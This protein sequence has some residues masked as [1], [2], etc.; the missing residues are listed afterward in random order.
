MHIKT[1]PIERHT[2][3]VTVDNE[4]GVL[5]RIAGM[6]SARGYNIESL[7]VADISADDA[8]SRITIVTNG[9][10]AVIEQVEIAAKYSG[11][12]D[13]QK[14][15]VDRAAHFESLRLPASLDYL[16]VAAL[17]Y[18]VRQKLARHR[19]ETLGQASRMSGI[20]PAAISLLLIHLKRSRVKGF[21]QEGVATSS[22]DLFSMGLFYDLANTTLGAPAQKNG[23][24]S[25]IWS[26]VGCSNPQYYGFQYDY[27][28]RMT[29]AVSAEYDIANSAYANLN[30]YNESLVYDIRGNFT[31]TNRKG[32][33]GTNTYGT[34]DNLL[35]VYDSANKNR[36]SNTTEAGSTLKGFKTVNANGTQAYTYDENGNVKRDPHKSMTVK[37]FFHNFA[38]RIDLDN[39]TAISWVYDAAGNKLSKTSGSTGNNTTHYLGGIEY[40]GTATNFNIEAIYFGDGRCTPVAGGGWRYE[41]N[42]RDHLGNTRVTFSDLNK[43]GSVNTTEI[44]QQHHH[45]PFGGNIEGLTSS[46]TPNKYQFNGTEWNADLGLERYDFGDRMYDPWVGRWWGIDPMASL[47]EGSTPYHYVFNNPVRYMDYMGRDTVADPEVILSTVDI[48]AEKGQSQK[49]EK[50]TSLTWSTQP[51]QTFSSS[52]TAGV[53]AAIRENFT[54]MPRPKPQSSDELLGQRLGDGLCVIMGIV[55]TMAGEA[56][57]A[58]A[59]AGEVVSAGGATPLAIPLAALG[60]AIAAHG[61]GTAN[62]AVVNSFRHMNDKVE[63]HSGGATSKVPDLPSIDATGK[64][65][66]T[67]PKVEDFGKYTKDEL[68]VLLTELNQSVKERIRITTIK[69]RDRGHGQRQGAEHDLI[70]SLEKYLSK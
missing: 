59:V 48:V 2:L 17:S 46:N 26:Q 57:T 12:I 41:Y 15:E 68:Q 47:H 52:F 5:A 53:L 25:H 61:M 14:G 3:S 34:I 32:L 63:S 19:P 56:I 23:N 58:A 62:V 37:Y 20:T 28:D 6:F 50:G 4:S 70:K 33:T 31:S 21:A 66:G 27:L 49:E 45:Y 36:I 29:A 42:L 40:V 8:V 64:V 24:I 1:G 7:T 18:E 9:T 10:P 13:R 43:D 16:Q 11:Y 67:L 54:Y 35:H 38:K 55:E 65:H 44:L 69:G 51:I 22:T 30:R 60:Q 39:G